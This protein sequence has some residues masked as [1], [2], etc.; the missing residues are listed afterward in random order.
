MTASIE[1]RIRR[2]EDIEAVRLLMARYHQACDGWDGGSHED[3]QA[4]ADLFTDDGRWG[5]PAQHPFAHGKAE[6]A[7]LAQRLQPIDWIVHF[8]VNPVVEVDGDTASAEFKGVV[9]MRPAADGPVGWTMGIYR[10][11]CART[12]EG[13]RFRSLDWETLSV[14]REHTD[15]DPEG[16]S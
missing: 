6:I 13:W 11:A 15:R 14:T 12:P 2:L 10:A 16:A 8:V 7:G 4:I 3:P 5:I 1:D 9:R